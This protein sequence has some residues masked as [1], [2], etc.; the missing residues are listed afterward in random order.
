MSKEREITFEWPTMD[1]EIIRFTTLSEEF[2][3]PD[4]FALDFG[5]FSLLQSA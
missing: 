3:L 4:I 1:F 2:F 5:N